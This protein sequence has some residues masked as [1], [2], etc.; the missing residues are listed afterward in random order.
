MIYGNSFSVVCV[1]MNEEKYQLPPPGAQTG[2][3]FSCDRAGDKF[4]TSVMEQNKSYEV[5]DIN[6]NNA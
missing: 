2:L 4:S 1:T 5:R 3:I 6:E